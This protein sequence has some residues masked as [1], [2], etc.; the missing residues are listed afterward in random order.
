MP[1]FLPPKPSYDGKTGIKL[2]RI[3]SYLIQRLAIVFS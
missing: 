2:R 1:F 3:V